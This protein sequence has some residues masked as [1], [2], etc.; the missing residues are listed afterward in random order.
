MNQTNHDASL[1][2]PCGYRGAAGSLYPLLAFLCHWLRPRGPG[3]RSAARRRS[4]TTPRVH[5]RKLSALAC[6]IQGSL[7]ARL[8]LV[9]TLLFGALSA[10]Q[11]SWAKQAIATS[12]GGYCQASDTAA[13]AEGSTVTTGTFWGTVIF[14]SGEAN[15]TTLV[16]TPEVTGGLQDEVFVARFSTAGAL[17]WVRAIRVD[18]SHLNYEFGSNFAKVGAIANASD[19]SFFITGTLLA[20]TTF[21]FGEANQTTL[22]PFGDIENPPISTALFLAHYAGDGTL[23]WARR[24]AP[25][26]GVNQTRQDLAIAGDGGIYVTGTFS[27]TTRTVEIDRD[28][29][30]RGWIKLGTSRYSPGTMS[31]LKPKISAIPTTKVRRASSMRDVIT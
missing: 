7:V 11:L 9:V 21:G 16:S 24:D 15:Q 23:L 17:Q 12:T 28:D 30:K 14:G 1:P 8:A 4:R 5:S 13:L 26:V 29:E 25:G 27:S 18:A 2:R 6:W 22:L 31:T 20:P 19:G 3:I 10:Q